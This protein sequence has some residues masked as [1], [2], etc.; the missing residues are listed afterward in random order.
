MSGGN[1]RWRSGISSYFELLA[2]FGENVSFTLSIRDDHGTVVAT[3]DFSHVEHDGL[4]ALMELFAE[5]GEQFDLPS[6]ARPPRPSPAE[7]VRTLRRLGRRVPAPAPRFT[8]P[9][10][11]WEAG[12]PVTI[13]PGATR[14]LDPDQLGV[15]RACARAAGASVTSWMLWSL[16]R[17]V[18]PLVTDPRGAGSWGL[19]IDLRGEGEQRRPGNRSA[20][21]TVDIERTAGAAEVDRVVR[22]LVASN[23][24]WGAR[25]RMTLLRLRGRRH[26]RRLVAQQ[27]CVPG[28]RRIGT[29]SN[30][31][32][33]GGD[34][35]VHRVV[36]GGG[37]PTRQAP[38]FAT[39]GSWNGRCALSL[40][41]HPSLTLDSDEVGRWATAWRAVVLGEPS[42]VF[43]SGLA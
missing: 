33:L 10:T 34:P 4:S 37:I 43:G 22:G 17:A 15:V 40:R 21:V 26:M 13:R 14:V 36:V 25:D 32:S 16:H 27:A 11:G 12:D 38:I 7:R 30:I 2:E 29:F 18:A 35:D 28:P 41:A 24:A 42:Q 23:A 9:P 20:I 6:H 1:G 3:R 8:L 19:P 39:A 31:G 5:A